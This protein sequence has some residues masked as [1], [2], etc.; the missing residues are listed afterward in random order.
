MNELSLGQSE[1][2][3]PKTRCLILVSVVG[4]PIHASADVDL[5]NGLVAHF[6]FN[7]DASDESGH[8]FNGQLVG[9]PLFV[10]DELGHP[11][12]AIQFNGQ[13]QYVSIPDSV[14]GPDIDAFTFYYRL[15]V[16][17]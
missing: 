2:Y 7:G 4:V 17:I 1:M 9:S 6:G 12:S 3:E 16:D 5:S 13:N 10:S 14:F 8:G 15:E 11:E